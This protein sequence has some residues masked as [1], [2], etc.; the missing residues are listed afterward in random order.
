[1]IN[2][3]NVIRMLLLYVITTIVQ[4]VVLN[5]LSMTSFVN[6]QLYILFLLSM[7][8]GVG[9]IPLMLYGFVTGIVIDLFC[10]TP[11]MHASACVLIAY[12]RRYVLNMLAYR[13]AYKSDEIPSVMVYGWPW[14]VKYAGI[15]VSVHHV[16]LFFVEQFDTL[17]FWPT[18]LRVV[19]S[20]LSTIVLLLL[21]QYFMP[22]RGDSGGHM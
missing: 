11:G 4:I 22:M 19:L 14:Y 16:M 9:T 3:S 1:M 8:F 18:L 12:I 13:D 2:S 5:N 10:D 21:V 20:I 17:F 15:L 7:P 6:P